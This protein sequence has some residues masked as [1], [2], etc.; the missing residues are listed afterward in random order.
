MIKKDLESV[1]HTRANSTDAALLREIVLSPDFRFVNAAP[2]SVEPKQEA[3]QMKIH[4]D[5]V[6]NA[7][8]ENWGFESTI[9][10]L[11]ISESENIQFIGFK[12]ADYSA[13]LYF[14]GIPE[15][16]IGVIVTR[17]PSVSP[18]IDQSG[19]AL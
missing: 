13:K 2:V 1:I 9:E 16:V 7:G 10:K 18:A 8:F 4:Y 5:S 11:S 17:R 14:E 12:G 3:E 6:L 19:K 15:K